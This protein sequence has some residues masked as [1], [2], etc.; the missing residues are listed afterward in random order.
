MDSG[1]AGLNKR[2]EKNW[3]NRNI[4]NTGWYWDYTEYTFVMKHW[5]QVSTE[6]DVSIWDELHNVH[7]CTL[8]RTVKKPFAKKD[9]Y[10]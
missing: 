7:G 1:I 2:K 8:S 10:L 9:V 6:Q 4:N 5:T 3:N